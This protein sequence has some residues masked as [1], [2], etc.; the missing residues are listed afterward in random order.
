M[1]EIVVCG[2]CKGKGRFRT[3]I[4]RACKGQ[5][6]VTVPTLEEAETIRESCIREL[7]KLGFTLRDLTLS[8]L[9]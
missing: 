8:D 1:P 2:R 7:G 4:C 6:V 3:G 5:K 9:V